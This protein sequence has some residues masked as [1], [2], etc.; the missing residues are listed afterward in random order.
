MRPCIGCR[1]YSKSLCTSCCVSYI[2][3]LLKW[4]LFSISFLATPSKGVWLGVA[5]L[6]HRPGAARRSSVQPFVAALNA[7]LSTCN[8]S[9][10]ASWVMISGGQ[11]LTVA[12][13]TGANISRPRW[14]HSI[15]MR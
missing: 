7:S 10:M 4:E 12:M 5:R 1:T 15:T 13:P 6:R 14:K 2:G 9:C 8:P 3:H 11:I